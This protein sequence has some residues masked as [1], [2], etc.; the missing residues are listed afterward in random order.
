MNDR[1][2]GSGLVFVGLA[3][4]VLAL[5]RDTGEVVWTWSDRENPMRGFVSVLVDGDRLMVGVNGYLTCL[6][7][8]GSELWRNPLKG[9]GI[10]VTCIASSRGGVVGAGAAEAQAHLDATDAST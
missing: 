7:F 5:N 4:K 3:G 9:M 2:D 10:G 1:S 8:A 6:D